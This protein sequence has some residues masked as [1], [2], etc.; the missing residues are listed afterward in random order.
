MDTVGWYIATLHQMM[1][2]R[3]AARFLGMPIEEGEEND[4]VLCQ[5][6]RG[7]ATKEEVERAIGERRE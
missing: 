2:H 4:C 5:F 7:A 1:G 6:E 3:P